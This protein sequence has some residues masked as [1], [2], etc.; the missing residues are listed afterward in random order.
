MIGSFVGVLG[1][2]LLLIVLWDAFETIV[3]PRRVQRRIRLTRLFYRWTWAFW[4]SI[5]RRVQLSNRR[6]NFLSYYGPLSLLLLLV[7]WAVIMVMSFAMMQWGFG[8]T[9]IG[10]EG[11]VNFGGALYLSGST[12]FTLGIGDITP[13]TTLGRL[14]TIAEAGTGIAFL[15]LVIGYLPVIYQA[16]SRREAS[17]SLLDA[18]AGSPPSA[19]E[20]LRRHADDDSSDGLLQFLRDWER[21]SSELLES[22]LSY[23]VLVFYRSQHDRESWLSAMTML[24]DVCAL[25]L[26]GIDGTPMRSARLTFAIARHAAVDL[27]QIFHT[28]PRM[29]SVD[30]LPPAELARLR[31]ILA[32]AGMQLREGPEADQKLAEIRAKYEPYVSALADYLLVT[33]PPWIPPSESA[34]DWQTSVWE[35]AS[36]AIIQ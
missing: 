22:H 27:S 8:V 10:P 14:L 30:R 36:T 4:A 11:P 29:P 6:D 2:A 32:E 24:L 18:R 13:R 19:P 5:G 7:V 17:I 25:I 20:L 9:L 12:F 15:A 28:P 3:L 33:L 23:P 26:V 34:D 1:L 21:W 35:H 31:N 16:F